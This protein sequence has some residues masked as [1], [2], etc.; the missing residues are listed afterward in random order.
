LAKRSQQEDP[1]KC[2]IQSEYEMKSDIFPF[3][4][5][6]EQPNFGIKRF[7]YGVY[8]GLLNLKTEK[9]EGFGVLLYNNGRIYEGAWLEDKR[10]GQGYEEF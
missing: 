1:D 7:K 3:R 6:I 4:E 10:N 9:R 8:K 5:V 2:S